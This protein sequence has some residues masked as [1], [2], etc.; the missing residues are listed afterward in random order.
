M[1]VSRRQVLGG[2]GAATFLAAFSPAYLGS[3]VVMHGY[4]KPYGMM[5]KYVFSATPFHCL[6]CFRGD[7]TTLMLVDLKGTAPHAGKVQLKGVLQA[8]YGKTGMFAARLKDA[9]CVKNAFV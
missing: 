5:G 9:R 7:E 4:L 8:F 2:L 1:N 6:E 3:E